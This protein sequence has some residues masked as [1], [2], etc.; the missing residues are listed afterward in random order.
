MVGRAR[1]AGFDRCKVAGRL[2]DIVR[3]GGVAEGILR[4]IKTIRPAYRAEHRRFRLPG[5]RVA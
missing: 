2:P 4:D 3:A 5:D 1:I